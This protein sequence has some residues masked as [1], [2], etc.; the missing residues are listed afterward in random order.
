M[1][2]RRGDG[3]DDEEE[4]GDDVDGVAADAGD[5]AERREDERADAVAEDV[6]GE[7]ERGLEGAHAEL[8]HDAPG[9]GRVNGRGRVDDKGVQADDERN[10]VALA[11]GPVV[12][13]GLVVGK[14]PVDEDGAVLGLLR[15]DGEGLLLL[16][17]VQ[18]VGLERRLGD[19]VDAGAVRRDV[20]QRRRGR[21]GYRRGVVAICRGIVVEGRRRLECGRPVA[22]VDGR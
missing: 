12:R 16:E 15:R 5:L 2:E 19:V 8:L 22:E 9:G 7:A 6:E 1:H 13:V 11:V 18:R 21:G 10:G 3:D 14:V 4:H 20:R 17:I